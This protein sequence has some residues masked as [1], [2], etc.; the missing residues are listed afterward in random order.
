MRMSSGMHQSVNISMSQAKLRDG[1]RKKFPGTVIKMRR[2]IGRAVAFL[3]MLGLSEAQESF[4]LRDGDRVVF[5]GDSI[6]EP[7]LYTTFVE[8]YAVT[9]FPDLRLTFVD[10]AWGGDRVTGGRG[11]PIDLRLQ[12]DVI[13]QNPTVLAIMLGINDGRGVP[14][15]PRLFNIF[16]TGYEHIVNV[17]RDALPGIRITLM[18]PSPYDEVTR[19]PAFE[20]G[21]NGVLLRYGTFVKELGGRKGLTVA[22]LNAPLVA[23]LEKAQKADPALAKRIA[24]DGTHPGLAGHLILAESLLKAWNAT[25]IVSLV[26]ID[27]ARKRV[28]HAVNT[29][30]TRVRTIRGLSWMEKDKALPFPLDSNDPAMAMA[31]RCSDVVQ[32]LDQQTLKVTGLPGAHY[33]LK[34]DGEQIAVFGREQLEEGVNLALLDTPMKKQATRVHALT[35]KRNEVQFGRWRQVQVALQNDSLPHKQA[36]L[37]ALANLEQGLLQEQRAAAQPKARRY[38]LVRQ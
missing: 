1:S 15:D 13:S 6:T 9:R 5:D 36:A 26:E 8:T 16:A 38:Q 37:D 3:I 2:W 33:R 27:A 28:V 34:I 31:A 32:A 21:Y 22:D 4:Q 25:A 35:R 18:Q 19:P 23:V 30:V 11:G 24:G 12:R 17:V 14:Y 20:G 10:S 7:R 29:S